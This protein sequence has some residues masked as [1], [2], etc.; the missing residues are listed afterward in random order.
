MQTNRNAGCLS[1]KRYGHRPTVH[2]PLSGY[3]ER[4][5]VQEY[6]GRREKGGG[7]DPHPPDLGGANARRRNG[8]SSGS[9]PHPPNLGGASA[10]TRN[11]KGGGSDPL[12]P[13]SG[14][15]NARRRN[16]KSS[17]S[18]PLPPNLGGAGAR[19]FSLISSWLKGLLYSGKALHGESFRQQTS[20]CGGRQPRC[21]QPSHDAYGGRQQHAL[22]PPHNRLYTTTA[23]PSGA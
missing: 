10:R 16:G 7:S 1:L 15:T 12:P 8:K 21:R 6:R 23:M 18:D 22:R 5:R 4:R 14:G 11:G 19:G 20:W 9:D 17:G 3:F 2:N 13:D